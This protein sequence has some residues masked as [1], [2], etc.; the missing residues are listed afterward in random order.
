M[1]FQLPETFCLFP[2]SKTNLNLLLRFLIK[3]LFLS[4]SFWHLMLDVSSFS[5]NIVNISFT[6]I[7]AVCK[8][9]DFHDCLAFLSFIKV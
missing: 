2:L 5:E 1:F 7:K 9:G 8:F 4:E 6:E 3:I